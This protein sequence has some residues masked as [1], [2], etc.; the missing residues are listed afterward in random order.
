MRPGPSPWRALLRVALD[1]NVII[2]GLLFDGNE[3]QTLN[4]GRDGRIQIYLSPF[5]LGEVDGVLQRKFQH[6][7]EQSAARLAEIRRWAR[8]IEPAQSVSAISRKDADN[9]ILECCLECRADYLVTGDRRDRL[10]LRNFAGTVICTAA[11]FL[12]LL[13]DPAETG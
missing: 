1:T 11:A 3:R 2:S 12:I 4:L 13:A 7:A 9:R 6:S 8:I 5:I 10:P